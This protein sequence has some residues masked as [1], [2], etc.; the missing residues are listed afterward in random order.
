VEPKGEPA[1]NLKGKFAGMDSACW[2]VLLS[3]RSLLAP[4]LLAGFQ[5]HQ[6]AS[7]IST[8]FRPFLTGCLSLSRSHQMDSPQDTPSADHQDDQQAKSSY[9]A[10]IFPSSS[11]LFM[12]PLFPFSSG[13]TPVVRG[14]RACTVCRAAKVC[15]SAIPISKT[16]YSSTTVL[17]I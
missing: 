7:A 4:F 11:S 13:K 1:G 6:L 14:A 17:Y 16:R 5:R 3:L 12:S 15:I 8:P 9:V 10:H 2:C